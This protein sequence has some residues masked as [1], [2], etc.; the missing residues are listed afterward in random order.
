MRIP[1]KTTFALGTLAALVIPPAVFLGSALAAD[2]AVGESI[3]A[4]VSQYSTPRQN[5]LVCSALG[6]IPLVLLAAVLAVL[7]RVTPSNRVRPVLALGGLLPILAVIVW[8][9]LDFWQLFLPSRTYPGFP[10]GLGFVIGPVFFAPA[11]MAVG[12]LLAWLV[13][14]RSV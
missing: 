2:M 6:L 8:V 3:A 4:M 14:R 10:H 5:L 9:H 13:S 11:A 7:R 12:M 1:I